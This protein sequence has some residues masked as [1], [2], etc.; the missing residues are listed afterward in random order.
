MELG[1]PHPRYL[2][3]Y[4]TPH[5]YAQWAAFLTWLYEERDHA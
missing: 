1:C 4:L 5:D 3:L 2:D